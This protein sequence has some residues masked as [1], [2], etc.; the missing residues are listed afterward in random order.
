MYEDVVKIASCHPLNILD[1]RHA[2]GALVHV[3]G[4]P[5][6]RTEDAEKVVKSLVRELSPNIKVAW[7]ACIDKGYESRAR[8][9]AIMT[10]IK[11]SLPSYDRR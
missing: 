1:F 7:S 3:T 4:G 9:I 5:E 11:E 10:G 8:A 2:T 6:M